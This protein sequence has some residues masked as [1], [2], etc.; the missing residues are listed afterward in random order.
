MGDNTRTEENDELGLPYILNQL[1]SARKGNL[2][3]SILTFL[4]AVAIM[5][6]VSYLLLRFLPDLRHFARW[7]YLGLFV[8][9]FIA[10]A[11]FFLPLP[12]LAVVFTAATV[13]SPPWVALVASLGSSL[14]E[15]SGYYMGR[16]GVTG[17][18]KSRLELYS[19]AER[20]MQ[21]YGAFAVWFFAAFPLFIFDVVAVA[22]GAFRLPVWKFLLAIWLGRL[23]RAYVEVYIILGILHLSFP[24]IF[25]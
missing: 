21:R 24:F 18:I 14:G 5:L 4:L 2:T 16:F 9:T 13:L 20:W 25:H 11:T 23:P 12:G 17:L 7:G 10:S 6:G 22:A 3:R 1:P 19:K 8:A 15:L